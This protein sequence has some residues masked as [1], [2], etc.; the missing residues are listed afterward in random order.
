MGKWA[1]LEAVAIKTETT[2]AAKMSKC[3]YWHMPA[4]NRRKPYWERF[5]CI[6]G[7]G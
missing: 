4:A 5:G 1:K 2:K 3:R 6:A 7:K